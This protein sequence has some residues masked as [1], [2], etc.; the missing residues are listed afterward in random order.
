MAR[1]VTLNTIEISPAEN[2]WGIFVV[3]TDREEGDKRPLWDGEHIFKNFIARDEEE[4]SSV[5]SVLSTE[6]RVE[7]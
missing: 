2:G 7:V 4:V 3:Y 1:I 5:L 6:I